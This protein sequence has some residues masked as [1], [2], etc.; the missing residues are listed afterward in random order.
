MIPLTSREK[1]KL[2]YSRLSTTTDSSTPNSRSSSPALPPDNHFAYSTSLRRFEP[3]SVINPNAPNPRYSVLATPAGDSSTSTLGHFPNL[4][5][6]GGSGS[7]A[8]LGH[9]SSGGGG[10]IM[11]GSGGTGTYSHHPFAHTT[12]PLTPSS[13]YSTQTVAQTLS[14]LST[15]SSQGLPTSTVEAI[16]ELSGPNEFEVPAKDPVWKRFASQ[17]YESP[18]ILLL[19][20]SAG[21]SAVVGN[22]D[23]AASILA[24]IVIVVTGEFI[25]FFFLGQRTVSALHQLLTP[26]TSTNSWIC[27]RTTVRK[28]FRSSKQ[29][30]ATLLS[31]DSV[32]IIY[33]TTPYHP[34]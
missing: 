8:G 26:T 2:S 33:F 28:I 31:S 20:A 4:S 9:G 3:E 18:L 29:I 24:A 6:G 10:P 13:H 11:A 16:R 7:H 27:S 15:S 5:L 30:G 17:F 23:D 19:L 21:V 1:D 34:S 14:A 32:S 22:Y 12:A 25:C